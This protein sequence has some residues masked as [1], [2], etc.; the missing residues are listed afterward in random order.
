MCLQSY[1]KLIYVCNRLE[2]WQFKVPDPK[3]CINGTNDDECII[4]FGVCQSVPN[5]QCPVPY[6]DTGVCMQVY[7]ATD[8]PGYNYDFG[9]SEFE[10][11]E[12]SMLSLLLLLLLC[13]L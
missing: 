10:I 13:I 8:H 9:R 1:H 2:Y 4:Y 7:N 11:I 6:D 5:E 12:D 3:L